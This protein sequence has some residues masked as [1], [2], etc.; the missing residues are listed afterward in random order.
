P[1]P[2]GAALPAQNGLESEGPVL[3][4]G[5]G[6]AAAAAGAGGA[7]GD[8]REPAGAPAA[9]RAGAGRAGA[10][11]LRLRHAAA[12]A[13]AGA[14]LRRLAR[15]RLLRGPAVRA[16]LPQGHHGGAA[17]RRGRPD[18]AGPVVALLAVPGG[19]RLAGLGAAR[20]GAGGRAR[21]G[22]PLGRRPRQGAAAADRP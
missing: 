22:A 12:A 11:R 4:R 18:R 8:R 2:G 10:A 9:R 13:G 6:A 3:V 7:P 5:G 21:A 14:I 1:V 19:G 20:G 17:R 16:A 15:L